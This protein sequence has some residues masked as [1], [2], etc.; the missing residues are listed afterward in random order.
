MDKMKQNI[1]YIVFAAG[2]LIGVVLVFVGITIRGDKAGA[3][4]QRITELNRVRNAQSAADLSAIE[5]ASARFTTSLD[6][7]RQELMEGRGRSLT[8]QLDR[9]MDSRQFRAE[10]EARIRNLQQRFAA[11]DR[12][13][14]LHER[15][16]GWRYQAPELAVARDYWKLLNDAITAAQTPEQVREESIRLRLLEEICVTAERLVESGNFGQGGFKLINVL[17]DRTAA[18]ARPED[19]P[20]EVV[21]Y[22]LRMEAAPDLALALVNELVN[23]TRLTATAREGQPSRR[24]FPNDLVNLAASNLARPLGVRYTVTGALKDAW[25]I[26]ADLD[27]ESP[28]GRQEAARIREA[29][30]EVRPALPMGFAAQ[31][32]AKAFNPQWRVVQEPDQN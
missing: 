10:A 30:A 8:A 12:S 23:P 7:A 17:I 6:A 25:N 19:A 9:P 4:D 29:M 16:E 14:P 1:H 32:Q 5:Q 2:I 11:L 22:T 15:L 21:P 18:P 26:R 28:E 20:W 24:A 3:L 27:P 13:A 31:L